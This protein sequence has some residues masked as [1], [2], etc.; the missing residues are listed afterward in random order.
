MP[1]EKMPIAVLLVGGLGTRLRS[2]ISERPKALAPI[3]DTPFLKLVL[4][5]LKSQGIQRVVLCT[6]HFAEQIEEEFGNGSQLGIEIEYSR[7]LQPLGTGGAVKLAEKYLAN[8]SEFI[9]LNGDSFLELEFKAFVRVHREN[10]AT[11]TVALRRVSNAARYGTVEVDKDGKVRSFREK[12]G[13]K[14]PGIINGGVY[15]FEREVLGEMPEGVLS[16]E[17]DVLPKLIVQ[18]VRGFQTNGLF[19][20]IGTPEDYA[21]AQLLL[22]RNSDVQNANVD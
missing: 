16:L 22:K 7:E 20:D 9:V 21:K 2:V 6:G 14:E 3:G 1:T 15:I 4:L 10:R 11:A 13:V 8:C 18:N 12:L 5:E 19:I 17:K